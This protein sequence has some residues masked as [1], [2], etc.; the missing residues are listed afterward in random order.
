MRKKIICLL[1]IAIAISFPIEAKACSNTELARLKNMAAN[2]AHDYTYQQSGNNVSFTIN[3][4][5]IRPEIYVYDFIRRTSHYNQESTTWD[6][7][8]GKTMTY[9]VKAREGACAERT[10]TTFYITLPQYNRYYTS[11][12]CDKARE[13][14]LC[15]KWYNNNDINEKTF[16][17]R[18]QNYIDSK[19]KVPTEK[20]KDEELTWQEK[21]FEFVSKYY[22][23]ILIPLVVVPG[24]A[25]I[26]LK[27]KKASK[28]T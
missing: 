13:Y 3:L 16:N 17:E 27:K 9:I 22:L 7:A 2:I 5:N 24:T 1:V 19:A 15:D 23:Y 11:T 10:L 26:I 18:V 14:T 25:L 21:V 4:R 6:N 12:I 8:P 20:E 28:Y